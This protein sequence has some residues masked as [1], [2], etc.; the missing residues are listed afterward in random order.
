MSGEE[1][2]VP[3]EDGEVSSDAE[4]GEL[5]TMATVAPSSDEDKAADTL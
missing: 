2:D 5:L 1:A 4:N 3:Q